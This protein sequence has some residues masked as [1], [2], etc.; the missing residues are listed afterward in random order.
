MKFLSS[1]PTTI[2]L[3]SFPCFYC[4][5]QTRS[6][7]LN[8]KSDCRYLSY[9]HLCHLPPFN[10]ICAE[11]SQ[12]I[13]FIMLMTFP[14]FCVRAQALQS[15]SA[16]CRP[17]DCSPPGSSVHRFSQARR[18]EWGAVPSSRGPSHPGTEA[19]SPESPAL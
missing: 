7:R 1:F 4:T 12:R 6:T 9:L 15:C 11:G 5:V 10:I 17:I 14:C 2:P 18:L 13:H 8:R 19:T 3:I 16:L